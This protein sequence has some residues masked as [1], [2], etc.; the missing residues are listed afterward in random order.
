MAS[1]V[2]SLIDRGINLISFSWRSKAE[3]N[4]EMMNPFN[5]ESTR[6]YAFTKQQ[7]SPLQMPVGL[8]RYSLNFKV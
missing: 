5:I 6:I 8:K 1:D 4:D 3:G 2:T 7:Y